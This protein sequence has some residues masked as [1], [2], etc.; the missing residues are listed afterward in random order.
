MG[1]TSRLRTGLAMLWLP[2]LVSTGLVVDLRLLLP[3]GSVPAFLPWLLLLLLPP[4]LAAAA[5][6]ACSACLCLLFFLRGRTMCVSIQER[7][8]EP[9]MLRAVSP[10]LSVFLSLPLSLSIN[11]RIVSGKEQTERFY[12][13]SLK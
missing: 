1:E 4:A 11:G 6:A 10:R 3:A 13:K 2:L 12:C 8:L 7:S 9:N 5:A